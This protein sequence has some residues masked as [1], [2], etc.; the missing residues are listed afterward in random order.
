MSLMSCGIAFIPQK[1]P[2]PYAFPRTGTVLGHFRSTIA[3]RKSVMASSA[4]PPPPS[5]A[6]CLRVNIFVRLSL[7]VNIIVLIA[8]CTRHHHLHALQNCN[9]LR[10]HRPPRVLHVR[11][12][13]LLVGTPHRRP[14]NPFVH[15]FFHSRAVRAIA[16]AACASASNIRSIRHMLHKTLNP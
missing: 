1:S 2:A 13:R 9:T 4:H 14:R 6:T 15:L 16:C 3:G 11:A 10:M 5:P 12:R 8:V 7:A